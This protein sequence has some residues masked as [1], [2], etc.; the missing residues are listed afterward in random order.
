MKCRLYHKLTGKCL[1]PQYSPRKNHLS[2]PKDEFTH[3]NT[4][5]LLTCLN[6]R[7]KMLFLS[8]QSLHIFPE[9]QHLLSKARFNQLINTYHP[10]STNILQ[11]TFKSKPLQSIS[12]H[13]HHIHNP[14]PPPPSVLPHFS[15]LLDASA[16]AQRNSSVMSSSGL[17]LLGITYFH[18][19]GKY[20]THL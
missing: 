9:L 6:S 13:T 18:M 8:R 2:M 1:D 17:S 14:S 3:S 20:L 19:F 10:N 4:A 12:N 16:S 5:A 11:H 7:L 15:A